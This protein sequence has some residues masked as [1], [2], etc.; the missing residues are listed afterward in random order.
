[1]SPLKI[2]AIQLMFRCRRGAKSG[3][4]AEAQLRQA[5]AAG[6]VAGRVAGELCRV[7]C[8]ALSRSGTAAARYSGA[9]EP[10]GT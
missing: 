1:M 4:E 8:R 6:A 5:A 9:T 3:G 10:A 2:A 7:R